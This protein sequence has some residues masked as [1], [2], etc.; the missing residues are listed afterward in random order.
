M[1]RVIST[2]AIVLTINTLSYSQDL[3]SVE[4]VLDKYVAAIGGK[5][6]V[7]KIQD[8]TIS[9]TTETPRGVSETEI[10]FK[11]PNKYFMSSYANGM[12]LFS[13]ICDGNKLV[14]K[15]SFGRGGEQP[16]KEG[17]EAQ[18][19]AIM[20][21][22][23]AEANYITAGVTGVV[24]GIEK[25]GDKDAYKVEFTGLTGNKFLTFFDKESGLKVKSLMTMEMMGQ[26]MESSVRY[27]D[28]KKFK[29][30]EVLVPAKTTRSGGRM[31]EIVAEVQSV[32]INK[33]LED[34]VFEIK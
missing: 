30:T 15:S 26:K 9:S 5:D 3:P 20:S 33:G 14:R 7:A 11:M 6:A 22:P 13:I 2:L 31:G 17:K 4:Q 34:K 23:F 19:E 16:P 10:K 1:K 25:V 8:V 32:K 21:N 24:Q 12:E 18:A 27:E 29:G 28:Y